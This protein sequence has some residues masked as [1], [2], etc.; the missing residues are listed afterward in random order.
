LHRTL[1]RLPFLTGRTLLGSA[2]GRAAVRALHGST[3]RPRSLLVL[4]LDGIGDYVLFRNF[5]AVLRRS[6]RYGKHQIT[7]CGNVLWRDLAEALDAD[8]VD[9]FEW[10]DPGAFQRSLASRWDILGRLS[11]LGAETILQPR[12]SREAAL[13]DALVSFLRGA[14]TIGSAGD[15]HNL[16]PRQKAAG[17][18]LYTRLI[19][20]APGAVFEF[21]INR[22]FFEGLLD[23]DLSHV[24]PRIDR[25]PLAPLA[26]PARPYAVLVPGAA[27]PRRRWSPQHFA[28]VADFLLAST[29]LDL[30]I[31]GG[32][33]DRPLGE[34]I[35]AGRA[36]TRVDDRTGRA[37]LRELAA[38][39]SSARILVANDTGA[40]HIAAASGTTTLCLSNGNHYGRFTEYP[41]H[42][43]TCV[44][45][46]YPP[47]VEHLRGQ[48]SVLIGKYSRG[49]FEDIATISS[50][51]VISVLRSMV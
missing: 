5:L 47:V 40:V 9:R 35:A 51:R 12:Q 1:S 23:E 21:E 24:L 22:S 16:S 7:L 15:T 32:P 2:L 10:I 49:S 6:A 39:I 11:A 3:L 26:R 44:T 33:E 37:T 18:E 42:L 8:A 30:V 46:I 17:D 20:P 45:T 25:E 28:D 29:D 34:R 43:A 36:S 4:R 19:A 13:E 48:P 31:C 41:R 27:E 50:E 38:L 14:T